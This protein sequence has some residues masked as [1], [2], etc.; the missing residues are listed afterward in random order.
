MSDTKTKTASSNINR[1]IWFS[2]QSDVTGQNGKPSYY[3]CEHIDNTHYFEDTQSFAP[4]C[5][6]NSKPLNEV[7]CGLGCEEFGYC[8][9]CKGFSAIRCQECDI[10]R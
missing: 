8:H 5:K 2:G 7:N 1:D 10:I 6:F 9:T 4:F 3:I